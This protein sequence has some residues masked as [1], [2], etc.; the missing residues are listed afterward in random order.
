MASSLAHGVGRDPKGSSAHP[1]PVHPV[2]PVLPVVVGIVGCS[3]DEARHCLICA[4]SP[5]CSQLDPHCP[6]LRVLP[7]CAGGLAKAW[8]PGVPVPQPLRRAPP[9]RL[10][11][12]SSRFMFAELRLVKP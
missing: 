9:S 1:G 2:P 8:G 12:G 11:C 5:V 3:R 10:P 6:D 7:C 4:A